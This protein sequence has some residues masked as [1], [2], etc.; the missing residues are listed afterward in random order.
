MD[1]GTD[2]QPGAGAVAA[3][4]ERGPGAGDLSAR[5]LGAII[6]A[7]FG[8]ATIGCVVGGLTAI[9]YGHLT[10]R[11]PFTEAIGNFYL[12]AVVAPAL[13]FF[14]N[15]LPE[16]MRLGIE[17]IRAWKGS[18]DPQLAAENVY[19]KQQVTELKLRLAAT[20]VTV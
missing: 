7:A 5:P 6:S 18:P 12:K 9:L 11:A 14:A 16:I 3:P 1:N 8:I 4:A 17:L 10:N 19:L 13:I 20:G 15:R 2:V